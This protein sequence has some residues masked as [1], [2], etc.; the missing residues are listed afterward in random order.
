[1]VLLGNDRGGHGTGGGNQ[2]GNHGWDQRGTHVD[3]HIEVGAGVG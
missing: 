2:C 1:M 3:D